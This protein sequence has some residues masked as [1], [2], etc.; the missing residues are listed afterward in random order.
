[1]TYKS[2]TLYKSSKIENYN[3]YYETNV[4]ST[5]VTSHVVYSPFFNNM[6]QLLT[7]KMLYLPMIFRM[8][9]IVLIS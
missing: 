6:T 2:L 1:M 3:T 8:E 4:H 9:S 7:L 5:A